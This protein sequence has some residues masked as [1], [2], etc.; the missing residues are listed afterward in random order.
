[1]REIKFRGR[2]RDGK[3]IYGIPIRTHLGTFIVFEENPHYCCLYGYMEI[4]ELD[5]VDPYTIGQFTGLYDKNNTEIFKGDILRADIY[6]LHDR[7][8]DNYYAEVCWWDDEPGFGLRIHKNPK[9][10]VKGI[11]DCTTESIGEI[12]NN[13]EHWEVI[14]NIYDNPELI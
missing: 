8:N 11:S 12:F 2:T 1:M 5:Y 10:K 6:P 4:D 13:E 14:G 7:N 9:S 3:W